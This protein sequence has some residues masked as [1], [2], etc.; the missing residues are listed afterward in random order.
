[1]VR[2][3][4]TPSIEGFHDDDGIYC[5]EYRTEHFYG[6][7]K[8]KPALVGIDSEEKPRKR[9]R[10]RAAAP[11]TARPAQYVDLGEDVLH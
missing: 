6:E 7:P 3:V 5:G 1:M 10:K 8:I 9:K 11:S 2:V 4:R